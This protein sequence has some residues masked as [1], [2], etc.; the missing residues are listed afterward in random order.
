MILRIIV[1]ILSI[2][3]LACQELP[4]EY[5]GEEG[6]KKLEK[7]KNQFVEGVVIVDEKLKNKIPKG[8]YFLIIAVRNLKEPMPIAVLRVKNPEFPYRFRITGKHK[9]RTDRMIE[10]DLILNARISKS[11]MAEAQKGD[12]V[13][14]AEAKAGQRGIKIIIGTEVP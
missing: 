1:L 9:I 2:F 7:Y 14:S 10:G 4:K 12:L 8:D 3:V 13:G 11:P 6:K 5:R